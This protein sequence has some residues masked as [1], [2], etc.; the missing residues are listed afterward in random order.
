MPKWV[1]WFM[2]SLVNQPSLAF[3]YAQ[4]GQENSFGWNAMRK[5]LEYQIPLLAKLANA[6][7]IRVETLG[8][9]GQWFRKKF[10]LTPA[11]SV[12]ALDD[13]KGERR[14]TVWYNSRFYRLNVLWEK[15]GFFIRD[16]HCFDED[17]VSPTHETPLKATSLTYETLPIVD[18]A[19]WSDSGRKEAG[20]F[21]FLIATDGS[22]SPIQPEGEPVVTE[23]NATYLSIVQPLKGGSRFSIVCAEQCVTF[24]SQDEHG[25]PLRCAWKII[26]GQ[27]LKAM[28]KKVSDRT[29]IYH[30]SGVDY[31]LK[32]S[33]GSCRQ[34]ED[35]SVQLLPDDAGKLVILF[36]PAS[37]NATA[38]TGDPSVGQRYQ[39]KPN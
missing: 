11:T 12:V 22:T 18:W 14:K 25:K 26:G 38:N 8:Q 9:S 35:G 39:R 20:M 2:D 15:N 5:G 34:L 3:A 10:P 23:M 21:P 16:I 4:A 31:E 33:A 17:I 28:I 1:D 19:M 36:D 29:L 30:H 13:W 37:I 27:P 24:S 6:G 32:L 7:E